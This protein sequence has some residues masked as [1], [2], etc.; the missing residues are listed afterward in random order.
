M[1]VHAIDLRQ[2]EPSYKVR[3]PWVYS[4]FL[5]GTENGGSTESNK[6]RASM[7]KRSREKLLASLRAILAAA[8]EFKSQRGTSS[9]RERFEEEYLSGIKRASC[10]GTSIANPNVIHETKSH[11]VISLLIS[12]YH[13][14]PRFGGRFPDSRKPSGTDWHSRE[15]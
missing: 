2:I 7:P 3:L 5:N 11:P 6:S 1:P 15:V 9:S 8:L 10:C 12:L 4:V 13:T 14:A